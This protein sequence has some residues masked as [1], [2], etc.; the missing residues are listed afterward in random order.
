MRDYV[1][2]DKDNEIKMIKDK[3]REVEHKL[4]ELND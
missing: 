4:M 3:Q 1:I 2:S